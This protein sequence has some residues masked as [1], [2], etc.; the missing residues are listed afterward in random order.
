MSTRAA[1][2]PKPKARPKARFIRRRLEPALPS[3]GDVITEKPRYKSTY[4]LQGSRIKRVYGRPMATP[5]NYYMKPYTIMKGKTGNKKMALDYFDA[6]KN[7]EHSLALPNSLGVSTCLNFSRRD[8][9]STATVS[10]N[11][12][13]II[14][15]FTNTQC[16]G[17]R[18]GMVGATATALA[19]FTSILFPDLDSTPPTHI[20]ASRL[21]ASLINTTAI[22]NVAGSVSFLFLQNGLEW[23]FDS[24][25][26]S[27]S[28]AF[29]NEVRTMIESNSRSK[30][31]SAQH[32]VGDTANN[33]FSLIPVSMANLEEWRLYG[34]ALGTST[35][36][37]DALTN[38]SNNFS[39]STLIIRI[40][41][42]TVS[43][44]Y[45]LMVNAQFSARY[46]ANSIISS[47]SKKDLY[48]K[49]E[50]IENHAKQL[51]GNGYYGDDLLTQ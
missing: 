31:Y 49:K 6:T 12:Q 20:R 43:N 50:V 22:T 45:T 37:K 34:N 3:I 15:Q 42:T 51:D 27:V 39:H 19:A 41:N 9:I 33:K 18:Y 16:V 7:L 10:D 28:I 11:H 5:S 44:T 46:P 32:F 35:S 26:N 29:Q 13:Y 25:T 40:E 38:G 24:T 1:S 21:T 17:I 48:P 30:I 8:G 14:L 4:S 47:I 2:K 36:I 23:E